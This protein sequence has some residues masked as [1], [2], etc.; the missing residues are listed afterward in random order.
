M[1]G[2]GDGATLAAAGLLAGL[3]G[4][5]GGITSLISY[6]ALL[7]VGLPALPANMTNLVAAVACWPGA[8]LAS[9]PEL[10]G[11]GPWLRRWVPLC[12]VGGAAGGVLLL[13]TPPGVFARVVPLLVALGSLALLVQPRLAAWHRRYRRGRPPGARGVALPVGLI[14]MSA[15]GGY[16]GAGSGVMVLALLLITV[17]PRLA[18]ANALKNMLVGAPALVSAVSFAAFGP[19][20]WTAV[21]PLGL[22][23][24]VGS[25]LGPRVARRMPATQLRW[26]AGSIGIGLAIQLWITAGG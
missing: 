19:V 23:M 10:A 6:P 15:Y 2:L 3:V 18:G 24:F 4:S 25:T 1:T 22:G 11:H 20:E 7:L 8:A 9:Q 26:L 5:A 16:F 21:A 14:A 12:G 13:S 17:E